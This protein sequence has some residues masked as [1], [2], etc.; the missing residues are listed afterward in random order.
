[1]NKR[2]KLEIIRQIF[3][4]MTVLGFLG[5]IGVWTKAIE[6]MEMNGPMFLAMIM[7]AM[8]CYIC[9]Y[10]FVYMTNKKG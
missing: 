3:G 7:A 4:F 9:G 1:M 8:M 2:I 6:D 5:V 10:V